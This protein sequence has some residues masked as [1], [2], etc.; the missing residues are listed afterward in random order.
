MEITSY[1][2]QKHNKEKI[3]VFV[4]GE[5]SFSI[6]INGWTKNFLYIGKVLTN[7]EINEI[8]ENDGKELALNKTLRILER[9]LKTESEIRKK[10]KEKE[11]VDNDIEYAITRAKEYGYI[12]D[13]YYVKCYILER[14][15]QNKWGSNKVLSN[16]LKKGINKE[17]IIF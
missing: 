1:E 9:G 10:L 3:N 6:S 14:A 11:F 16:L 5:Y 17:L 13:E 4:D 8:K 12:N 15:K 2:K 7:Q